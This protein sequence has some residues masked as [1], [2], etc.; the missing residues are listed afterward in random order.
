[1]LLHF[2]WAFGLS[3]FGALVL[4]IVV[5]LSPLGRVRIGGAT[6]K[7]ILRRWNWFAITLCTTI[8]TGILFWGA[9]EPMFHL[10]SPPEFAG[11]EGDER[12][13]QRFALSTLFL[14]WSFTPYAIYSIPAL[15][16]ALSFYNFGG[17][18]SIGSPL[19]L[20]F[21]RLAEGPGGALIDALALFALVTGVA[22]SLGAGVMTLV[23]GLGETFGLVDTVWTRLLVTAA[24]VAV[25]I[26]SSISGLQRGIKILSDYNL[27]FFLVLC[28]FVF[29]AGPTLEIVKLGAES[30]GVYLRDLPARG[31]GLGGYA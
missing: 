12:A 15:A 28:A 13:A 10:T 1:M 11:V 9:A 30:L 6:A 24:I 7:P 4:A 22:A 8:A 23:G 3:T 5:G 21:G 26:V 17:T 19:K 18:Y 25:Y 2:G 31:L 14:H 27:R 16:F 29:L 20:V